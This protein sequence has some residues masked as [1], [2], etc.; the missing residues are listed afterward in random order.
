MPVRQVPINDFL[1]VKYMRALYQ[2]AFLVY[3]SKMKRRRK[4]VARAWWFG[5]I[6]ALILIAIAVIVIV[7]L[8]NNKNDH[9]TSSSSITCINNTSYKCPAAQG[10]VDF[11]PSPGEG[12]GNPVYKSNQGDVERQVIGTISGFTGNE[13]DIKVSNGQIFKVL[14]PVAGI[15][16]WNQH[17]SQNYQGFK[18]GIGDPLNVLYTEPVNQHSQTIQPDQIKMS[19]VII[20]YSKSSSSSANSK[21]APGIQHVSDFSF[22]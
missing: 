14:F 18:V 11:Y 5:L 12:P 1:Q 10:G 13:V 19:D 6:L 4:P 8:T 9:K 20:K 7:S 2:A 22:D 21:I 16:W 3:N 17:R 15:G